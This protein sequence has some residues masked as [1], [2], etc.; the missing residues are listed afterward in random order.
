VAET[1]TIN[2]AAQAFLRYLVASSEVKQ[3]MEPS[4]ASF[5]A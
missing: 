4:A 2:K 3:K 5:A 1:N